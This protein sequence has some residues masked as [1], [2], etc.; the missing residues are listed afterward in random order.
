MWKKPKLNVKGFFP[1]LFDCK[2]VCLIQDSFAKPKAGQVTAK[3]SLI[4]QHYNPVYY[5]KLLALRKTDMIIPQKHKRLQQSQLDRSSCLWWP[6][7]PPIL[8]HVHHGLL[9]TSPC[10]SYIIHILNQLQV[11]RATCTSASFSTSLWTIFPTWK[12]V[13]ALV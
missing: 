7:S 12:L 10:S 1:Q 13:H 2:A 5:L 4:T 6:S 11:T 9:P 3:V 8:L